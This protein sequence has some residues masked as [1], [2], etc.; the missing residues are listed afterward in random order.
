MAALCGIPLLVSCA[1]PAS[2]PAPTPRSG[3]T[4]RLL[5]D[6]PIAR[7]DPQRLT[8]GVEAALVLRSVTRTL[9]G[10]PGG[11][12]GGAA[13]LRGDL[14]T[15]TGQAAEGGKQW[16]FTVRDGVRWEDGAPVTCEDVRYGVSR[17]FDRDQIGG[18]LPYP[19][20]LLDIPVVKDPAGADASAYAGPYLG[21]G[22]DYFDE[23][24]ACDGPR[25]TFRLKL[26]VPD[27]PAIVALPVFA[28]YRAAVDRGAQ[29]GLDVHSCGPYRL[30]APWAPGAGGR[31]VRNSNWA[32]DSDPLRRAYPDVIEVQ[33]NVPVDQVVARI[34]GDSGADAAALSLTDL[35]PAWHRQ[36]T[37]AGLSARMSNPRSGVVELLHPN[38]TVRP[39]SEP[40]AR[41]AL[42]MATDRVAFAAA[43]GAGVL[44][45]TFSALAFDVPGAGQTSPFDT[46]LT[47]DPDA[48]RARLVDA[49]LALPVP[50]RVAYRSS[51]GADAAFAALLP[52]WQRAGFAPELHPV[53][54][55]Y[56]QVISRPAAGQAYDVFRS[57]WYA[58][59]PSAGA[60]LP[61][62][63]DGRSNLSAEGTGRD[64]G[65]F[66][67]AG[68]NTAMES[69]GALLDPVAR[70]AAWGEVDLRIAR[71]GGHVALGE[72]RRLFVHGSAVLGYADNP[73]L[74]GWP[75]LAEI[76]VAK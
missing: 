66:D 61:L 24:V 20:T 30:A 36:L 1:G 63:F 58:D 52:G 35:P 13:A 57:V 18:G 22:Q 39:M 47:G 9:T 54:G 11:G 7:L 70:A 19:A 60:V 21:T 6:R 3:G 2:A 33:E 51:P 25:I 26:A 38:V 45:P 73:L 37:Q 72:R 71:L 67:D 76:S 27:F 14:T 12:V 59:Y 75:D 8:P 44:T 31:F 55:D 49:A 64:Y 68:V 62:L 53:S 16:S 65:S 32:S 74:W 17:S 10:Y 5:T 56:L 43:Y 48:A 41:Q 42:A 50:V 46:P 34:S 69:A 28:P 40:L 15:D 23:A 4:L 29:G